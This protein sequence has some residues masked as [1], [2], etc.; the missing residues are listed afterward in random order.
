MIRDFYNVK[1]KKT[2]K[3]EI[4]SIKNKV[5]SDVWEAIKTVKN[6]GNIAGSHVGKIDLNL[7]S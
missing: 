5:N 2:L 6:I 4:D 3:E 7:I 1:D